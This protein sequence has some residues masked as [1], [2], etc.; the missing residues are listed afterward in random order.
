MRFRMW[1]AAVAA[2]GCVSVA[3]A[4]PLGKLLK[5]KAWPANTSIGRIGS[6]EGKVLVRSAGGIL[7]AQHGTLLTLGSSVLTASNGRAQWLMD[8]DSI[9]A[10]IR[11]TDITVD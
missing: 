8:D 1:V 7:Q 9:F 4:A 10:A 11:K 3:G 2:A 5:A 6:V